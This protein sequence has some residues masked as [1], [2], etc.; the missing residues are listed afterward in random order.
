MTNL[1]KISL[2]KIVDFV[3][4]SNLCFQSKF[5]I[6][7][8]WQPQNLLYRLLNIGSRF[9]AKKAIKKNGRILKKN[10]ASIMDQLLQAV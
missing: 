3:P 7:L 9:W 2:T 5:I 6:D 4:S 8:Y 1:Q 10:P